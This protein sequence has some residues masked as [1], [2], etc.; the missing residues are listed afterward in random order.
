MY[1][2]PG[3]LAPHHYRRIET[4]GGDWGEVN[5]YGAEGWRVVAAV[6]KGGAVVAVIMERADLSAPILEIKEDEHGT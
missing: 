2:A 3:G 4:P 1:N 5:K 6:T